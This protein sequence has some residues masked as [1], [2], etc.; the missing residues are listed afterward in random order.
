MDVQGE[1]KELVSQAEATEQVVLMAR[2]LALL[3][4]YTAQVLVEQMG[5]DKARDMLCDIIWRYGRDS[6]RATRA[7]VEDLGLP[8]TT[9]NFKSGS[10]LPKWGWSSDSVVGED[11]VTRGRVTYCPLAAV[12]KEKGSQEL[13][14]IYCLVDEAKYEAY[15]G[16]WCRH[17][18]NLLDGDDCCIFDIQEEPGE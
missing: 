3:Y 17:A 13:G 5:D 14:R 8:T 7:R 18:K 12:W 1:S 10:D 15:N 4:H 2:R 11:G 16:S 6:G 9:E